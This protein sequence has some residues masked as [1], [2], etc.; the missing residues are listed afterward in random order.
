MIRLIRASPDAA[1]ARAALMARDWPAGD[2]LPL[3]ALI[4]DAGNVVTR[5]H[6]AADRGAGARHPGDPRCSA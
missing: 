1:T 5:R 2:V 6:G 4:D 3:L